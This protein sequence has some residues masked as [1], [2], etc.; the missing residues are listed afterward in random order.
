MRDEIYDLERAVIQAAKA[1]YAYG[2]GEGHSEEHE[3][4]TAVEALQAAEEGE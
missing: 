3:L 2:P 4:R 1:W